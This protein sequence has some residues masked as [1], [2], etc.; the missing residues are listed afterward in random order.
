MRIR[1]FAVLLL[2]LPA[3]AHAG[4]AA[5]TDGSMD[6]FG[7]LLSKQQE[8][9]ESEMD[10]RI[11]ANQAQAAGPAA[12]VAATPLPGVKQDVN[13]KEPVV[14]AIWGLVGKEVAEV[15]YKGRSVP[16]SM[17]EPYISKIDGWKLESIQPYEI[18]LV[19]MSGNRVTQRKS[20]SL[21][22]QGSG[23]NQ[24]SPPPLAAPSAPMVPP[25][26]A[27]PAAMR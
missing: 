26:I 16:V 24:S 12:P 17:Q 15:N 25:P 3:L 5:P 23:S 11:R 14:E 27:A 7:K 18:V 1:D 9:L 13:D 8:L 19:R 4:D 2:L 10:A 6:T 20:I 22:W 21:D